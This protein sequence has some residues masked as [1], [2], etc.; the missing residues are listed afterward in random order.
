[1]YFTATRLTGSAIS[2]CSWNFGDGGD[3]VET[4]NLS[5]THTYADDGNYEVTYSCANPIGTKNITEVVY[6]GSPVGLD[7]MVVQPKV[8]L[9]DGIAIDVSFNEFA[10]VCMSFTVR[11]HDG[12]DVIRFWKTVNADICP[13]GEESV[14]PIQ[15]EV[16]A[17]ELNYK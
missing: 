8:Y 2:S 1:M 9:A 10:D 15:L 7:E 3:I 6:V 17:L 16:I 14:D 13:C 5:V 4:T 12:G 11:P